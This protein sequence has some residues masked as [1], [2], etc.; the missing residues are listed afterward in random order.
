MLYIE[1][2]AP[3]DFALSSERFRAF[4][5]DPASLWDDGGLHR[6]IAARDVRIEAAP[7]G[8]RVEPADEVVLPVIRHLL[9]LAFDL[10][11]FRALA[12]RDPVLGPLEQ[13]LRG[14]RPMLVPDP[15]EMLV[16]SITAQQVSLVAATAVRRRLVERFGR[17][18]G[19][20]WAFPPPEAI[21]SVAPDELVAIGFSR[22]KAEYVLAAARS[23]SSLTVLRG[24][25]DDEVKERLV[26][27]RGIGEWTADWFLARHLGRARAWPAGDLGLRKAVAAF[28]GPAADVRAFGERFAP[29]ENLAAQYLLLG[30][31]T[32]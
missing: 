11:G 6:A 17:P 14:F 20:A 7:G 22:R 31:R 13:R 21:A 10:D 26:R 3:Y 15:W 18:V 12:G 27:L 19:V 25:P 30:L 4:G 8:V 1:V 9:G 32:P 16:G 5:R 2:P 28:Y 29:F 23:A 24:L